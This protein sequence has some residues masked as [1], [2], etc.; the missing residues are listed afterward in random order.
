MAY[1]DDDMIDDDE[2][3]TIRTSAH[4]TSRLANVLANERR[5]LHD[6]LDALGE[7]RG[8]FAGHAAALAEL[9]C[10]VNPSRLMPHELVARGM[11]VNDA[12]EALAVV[13]GNGGVAFDAHQAAKDAHQRGIHVTIHGR[14]EGGPW[15]KLRSEGN[16]ISGTDEEEVELLLRPVWHGTRLVHQAVIKA[17]VA[18]VTAELERDLVV[19][20]AQRDAALDQ[21]SATKQTEL[22]VAAQAVVAD[23][24]V[25][26]ARL[27][28]E[29]DAAAERLH[30]AELELDAARADRQMQE[31]IGNDL[32]TALDEANKRVLELEAREV[33]A[34]RRVPIA[35]VGC[36]CAACNE[37]R[38]MR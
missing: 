37:L 36:R 33:K 35:Q 31:G 30:K 4:V 18:R 19:T 10:A 27:R 21:V 7:L 11:L 14:A 16:Q 25:E 13:K 2:L 24:S 15:V 20:R 29:L 3:E 5:E 22:P 38:S 23:A 6:K 26:L 8:I 34:S 12:A 9:I 1:D 32:A 28:D 17:L